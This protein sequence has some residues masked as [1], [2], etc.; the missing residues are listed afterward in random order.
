MRSIVATTIGLFALVF[1]SSQACSSSS[2]QQ[3]FTDHADSGSGSGG[4][5][6]GGSSGGSGGGSGGSSGGSSGGLVGDGGGVMDEGG[7]GSITVTNTIYA[8]SDMT[9]YSVDPM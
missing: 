5:S 6:S 1:A 7:D 2:G 3:G 4:G 9:L 8:H